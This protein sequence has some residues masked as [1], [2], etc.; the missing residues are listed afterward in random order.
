MTHATIP[1]PSRQKLGIG[2]ALVRLSVGIE[3]IDDLIAD[4]TRALA[5]I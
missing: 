5:A 2:D 1:L 3:D 4:M